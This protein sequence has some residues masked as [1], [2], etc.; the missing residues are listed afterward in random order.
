LIGKPDFFFPAKRLAVFVDG[1]FWHGC[2]RCGHTPRTRTGFWAT[3]LLRNRERD[4]WVN[5]TL[6]KNGVHVI[7]LWEHAIQNESGLNRAV[8]RIRRFV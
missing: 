8:A 1:C 3:K 4:T 5:S 2:P 7:R 6:R